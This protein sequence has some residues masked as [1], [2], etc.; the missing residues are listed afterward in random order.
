GPAHRRLGFAARPLV[1][2]RARSRAAWARLRAVEG[3]TVACGAAAR[4]RRGA[5]RQ[6]QTLQVFAKPAAELRVT[7]RVFDR[8]L[9]VAELAA[10][11]IALAAEAIG[12]HRLLAHQRGN[13]VG[14]LNLAAGAGAQLLQVLEDCRSQHV[15]A[16]H[17][18]V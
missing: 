3:A 4:D 17:G 1:A 6:V 7:E 15:T 8:R 12:V 10:T 18:E 16:D 9:Q 5:G 2:A 13:A 14:E 11:V